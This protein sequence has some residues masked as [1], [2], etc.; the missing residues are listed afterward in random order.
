MKRV[1]VGLKWAVGGLLGV[2]ALCGL[3]G[4][5]IRH[6][7]S[8][9]RMEAV[10]LMEQARTGHFELINE[11]FSGNFLAREKQ[12]GKI[13]SFTVTAVNSEPLGAPVIVDF[14]VVRRGKHHWESLLSHSPPWIYEYH[15]ED[16]KGD[17]Q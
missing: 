16:A 11:G 2:L 8:T 15:F 9:T 6:C 1:H 13:E 17:F 14:D 10:K 12:A 4:A 7:E 5:W 3:G